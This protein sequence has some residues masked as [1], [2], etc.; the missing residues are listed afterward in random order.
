MTNE[1][2]Q[3]GIDHK[4]RLFIESLRGRGLWDDD[5]EQRLIADEPVEPVEIDLKPRQ[6]DEKNKVVPDPLLMATFGPFDPYR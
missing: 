5:A 1:I 6:E 2:P 4:L 3:T